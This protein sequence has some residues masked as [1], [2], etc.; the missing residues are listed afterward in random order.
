[1]S[2]SR[3]EENA[4]LPTLQPG[5][6]PGAQ[7]GPP[8][9]ERGLWLDR[10]GRWFHD[11]QHVRHVRLGAL[12]WRSIARDD[13]GSLIVTTGRDV[14][15][16][17][18]EDAPLQART[19]SQGPDGLVLKLCNATDLRLT[20]DTPIL[21][22]DEGQMRVATPD[23]RFWVRL[24]KP[25]AQAVMGAA[26]E[27]DGRLALGTREGPC[28]LVEQH[29]AVDWTAPRFSS[30]PTPGDAEGL[31]RGGAPGQRGGGGVPLAGARKQ[32]S[33]AKPW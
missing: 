2:S 17:A 20:P 16:F 10:D 12:L 14:L 15:P 29:G 7:E 23:G 18:A 24:L 8:G 28:H 21:V 1:M 25:A 30:P 9:P 31:E 6:G 4:P 22:D 11:G 5:T 26:H 19:V 32:P 3:H 13:A 33:T 27:H